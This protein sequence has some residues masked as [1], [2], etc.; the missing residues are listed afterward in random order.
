MNE[1]ILSNLVIAA[2]IAGLITA[3][4]RIDNKCRAL[5]VIQNIF[6]VAGIITS[7]ILVI[8]S[9]NCH[10]LAFGLI[11]I[12]LGLSFLYI[13]NLLCEE[14]E[15]SDKRS[16]RTYKFQRHGTEKLYDKH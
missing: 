16:K 12:I 7:V 9:D 8:V 15:Q 5:Q 3:M 13:F 14:K 2:L 6:F 11:Y 4:L 10:S 1:A